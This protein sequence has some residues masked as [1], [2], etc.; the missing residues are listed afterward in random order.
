MTPNGIVWNSYAQEVILSTHSGEMGILPNHAPF[1][2]GL[3]IG[4]MKVRINN[5]WDALALMGGF[6]ELE[7]NKLTLFVNEA[8]KASDIS[9]QNIKD[10]LLLA[11]AKFEQAKTANSTKE[12]IDANLT[13]LR[14]KA[15]FDTIQF[16]QKQK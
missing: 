6:A 5:K 3:D 4:V 12:K 13:L 2:T 7:N 10:D 14:V 11:K 9:D 1:L 15:R 16:L 8:E